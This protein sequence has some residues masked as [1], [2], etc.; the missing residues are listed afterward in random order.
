MQ[1]ASIGRF[2][3]VLVGRI[4][5]TFFSRAKPGGP[6]L[7]P[8]DLKWEPLAFE[9]NTGA[10]LAGRW[11]PADAPRGVVVLV[12]P[13]RRYGKHWFERTGWVRFLHEAGYDVLTFDLAG[14]GESVGPA[15]YYHE[16]VLAAVEVARRW[17]GGLPI[18]LV[19]V[20][21]GAF[22]VANASPRL[23]GVR[24][25]VLESP[26]PSFNAWY[27]RGPAR[28]GMDAFDR[29]FPRTSRAI[30]ADKN[31]ARTEVPRI[32][33]A[34]AEDDELTAPALTEAVARAA[35]A[36]ATRLVRV[37]GAHLAPFETSE[38]YRRAILE[39]FAT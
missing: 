19:G 36:G 23:A 13:D 37:P 33:V 22:A 10:R 4:V 29:L 2:E 28:W 5:R 35:P 3:R 9:G 16:D 12:H 17:S 25:L 31:V 1:N 38:A 39:T 27:G 18:H 21:L 20:S 8:A 34:L 11:F 30:R 32:L 14:Y 24:S 26:Y 15:T 6:W 7:P